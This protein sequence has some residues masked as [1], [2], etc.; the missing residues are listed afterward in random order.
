MNDRTEQDPHAAKLRPKPTVQ[1]EGSEAM[2]RF[3]PAALEALQELHALA[4]VHGPHQF[5]VDAALILK[6]M[7]YG[8]PITVDGAMSCLVTVASEAGRCYLKTGDNRVYEALNDLTTALNGLDGN[9]VPTA[10]TVESVAK[11]KG[12]GA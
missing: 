3:N 10:V 8:N 5:D 1:V 7:A 12:R 2:F 9:A 4:L 6:D 11:R